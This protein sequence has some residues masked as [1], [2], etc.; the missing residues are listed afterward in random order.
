L[1]MIEE[2]GGVLSGAELLAAYRRA[3][4][5]VG[6]QASQSELQ[7]L[8]RCGDIVMDKLEKVDSVEEEL[9]GGTLEEEVN[10]FE[11]RLIARALDLE[12]GSVTRAARELGLTHQGLSKILDGRQS[13]T[14]AGARRPKRNRRKSIMRQG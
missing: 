7:R 1:R 9:I 13:K 14:L 11:G 10:H 4:Q 8:R 3:D 2:I 6:D 12:N 5:Y